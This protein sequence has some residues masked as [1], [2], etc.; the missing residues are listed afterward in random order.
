MM[1]RTVPVLCVMPVPVYCARPG[2]VEMGQH[3]DG[4][5]EMEVQY[6]KVEWKC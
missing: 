6:G 5:V 1:R 4:K 2:A 3:T